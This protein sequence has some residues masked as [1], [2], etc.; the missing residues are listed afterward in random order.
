MDFVLFLFFSWPRSETSFFLAT[1]S[2]R[3]PT[4]FLFDFVLFYFCFFSV[5]FLSFGFVWIRRRSIERSAIVFFCVFLFYFIF[6]G[7][8]F[9]CGFK[10]RAPHS[11]APKDKKINASPWSW[12]DGFRGYWVLPSFFVLGLVGLGLVWLAPGLTGFGFEST[13][14]YR[15]LPGFTAFYCVLTGYYLVFEFFFFC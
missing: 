4:L 14:F 8:D 6:F 5:G 13:G 10:F 1:A 2:I 15:V 3:S 11:S 12:P 7:F 9:V